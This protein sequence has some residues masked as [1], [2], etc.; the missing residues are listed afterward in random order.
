MSGRGSGTKSAETI[1]LDSGFG[2]DLRL[3]QAGG[4]TAKNRSAKVRL[5]KRRLAKR[6]LAKNG[7]P[8][9][10]PLS[11][12]AMPRALEH[13]EKAAPRTDGF[14]VLMGEDAADLVQVGEVVDGPSSDQL[15]ECDAAKSRMMAALFEI[16]G[17]E[18]PGA[19]LVEIGGPQLRQLVED[20]VER[21]A[22]ALFELGEAVERIEGAGFAVVKDQPGA[23]H[24][25]GALA[26][27]QV[28]DDVEGGP[29]LVAFAV[30]RPTIGEAAQQRVQSG[31]STGEER[32]RIFKGKLGHAPP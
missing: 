27:V 8:R 9:P 26:M 24:P 20:L 28:T 29:G 32:D 2:P 12:L 19:K 5:A 15:S 22:A 23:W 14:A 11:G 10:G 18:L 17:R 30:P 25:V 16:A 3:I 13:P 6:R 21:F 4:Q 31:G 7:R 1:G